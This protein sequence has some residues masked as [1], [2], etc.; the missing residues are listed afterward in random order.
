MFS[1]MCQCLFANAQRMLIVCAV[2]MFANA[3]YADDWTGTAQLTVYGQ[4]GK[5]KVYVLKS[6]KDASVSTPAD[7]VAWTYD[8]QTAGDQNN[9]NNNSKSAYFAIHAKA[10]A[11]YYF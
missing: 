1:Q 4:T 11:R 2:I 8:S 6:E 3:S 10:D 7:D 9:V 5:G